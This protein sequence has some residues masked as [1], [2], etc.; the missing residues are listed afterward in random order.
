MERTKSSQISSQCISLQFKLAQEKATKSIKSTTASLSSAI[1]SL[2]QDLLVKKAEPVV[3]N[4]GYTQFLARYE[5]DMKHLE[6]L[7][8]ELET[9]YQKVVNDWV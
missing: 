8:K 9:S 6:S 5:S 2:S 4:E 1:K 3:L 7:V